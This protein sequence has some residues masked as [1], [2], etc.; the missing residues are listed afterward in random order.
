MFER[1]VEERFAVLSA[2]FASWLDEV[3]ALDDSG[4]WMADGATSI[5]AWLAGRFNMARGTA[6][7][8]VRVGGVLRELPEIHEAA[9]RGELSLDQLKPLTRFVTPEEDERWARRSV[10][11]SPA[12]LWAELRRRQR[13]EREQAVTD[14]KLRYLWMGWD[15]DR[16][17]LHLEGE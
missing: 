14:A 9:R 2:A 6:R 17:T 15:E 4:E 3:V 11:M 10:S 16:R 1:S 8:M 12:E 7:E 5:S 13:R